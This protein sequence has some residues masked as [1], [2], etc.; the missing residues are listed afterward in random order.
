MD[1]KKFEFTELKHS[2]PKMKNFVLTAVPL[3]AIIL[4]VGGFLYGNGGK[5]ETIKQQKR[6]VAEASSEEDVV[7]PLAAA[8]T[9]TT[10]E[11]TEIKVDRDYTKNKVTLTKGPGNSTRF[12]IST[13]KK[14]TWE[15]IDSTAPNPTIDITAY[16]KTSAVTLYFRGNKDLKPVEFTIPKETTDLKV[17]YEISNGKGKIVTTTSKT[18]NTSTAIEYRTNKNGDWINFVSSSSVDTSI[19]EDTGI[20]LEFRTKATKEERAGKIVKVKIK[21]RPTAPTVKVDFDEMVITGLK[22]NVTTYRVNGTAST[23]FTVFKPSGKEKTLSLE[24]L[25]NTTLSNNKQLPAATIEFRTSGD[26]KKLASAIRLIDI[27]QQPA[28]P[29]GV[30]LSGTTLTI[31]DASKDNPYEY[32]VLKKQETFAYENAK[33][34]AVKSPSSIVI[35]KTGSAMTIPGDTV[36]VRKAAHVDSQTGQYVPPSLYTTFTVSSVSQ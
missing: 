14:K 31:T 8:D 9:T 35:K 13:N 5:D 3:I 20:T 28:K 15:V 11:G 4:I 24:T 10:V 2:V 34:K 36:Y 6:I 19:Y 12:F 32:T 25:L 18:N 30:S 23:T 33:W 29:T 1:K 7:I 26:D 22:P 21:K 16:M 27:K 17:T